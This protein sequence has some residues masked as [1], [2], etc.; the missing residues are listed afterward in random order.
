MAFRLTSEQKE[1]LIKRLDSG[2]DQ[3]CIVVEVNGVPFRVDAGECGSLI[4]LIKEHGQK[5]I[6][7]IGGVKDVQGKNG[8]KVVGS[9][10]CS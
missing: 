7:I 5:N 6:K 3:G 8:C 2:E 10:S 9:D 4:G 1:Q